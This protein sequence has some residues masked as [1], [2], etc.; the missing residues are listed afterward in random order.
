MKILN[1]FKVVTKQQQHRH[2]QQITKPYVSLAMSITNKNNSALMKSWKPNKRPILFSSMQSK[3]SRLNWAERCCD[4]STQF[5]FFICAAFAKYSVEC[6][7]FVAAWSSFAFDR[8]GKST[9]ERVFLGVAHHRCIHESGGGGGGVA[10]YASNTI[11]N[12][13]KP[14][15]LKQVKLF[16]LKLP[17]TDISTCMFVCLYVVNTLLFI[18]VYK[19]HLL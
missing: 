6:W 10:D 18:S 13:L 19:L 11:W 9:L 3:L 2:Q 7:H 1:V 12:V 14:M 8:F 5:G 4:F 16:M 17:S 15:K